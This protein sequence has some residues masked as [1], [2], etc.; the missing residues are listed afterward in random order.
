MFQYFLCIAKAIS[1]QGQIAKAKTIFYVFGLNQISKKT[2][3]SKFCAEVRWHWQHAFKYLQCSTLSKA[4]SDILTKTKKLFFTFFMEITCETCQFYIFL[5]KISPL[6]MTM[7]IKLELYFKLKACYLNFYFIFFALFSLV[8]RVYWNFSYSS[9][10][11][12]IIL[13]LFYLSFLF[14]YLEFINV[15]YFLLKNLLVEH[16]IS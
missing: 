7:H 5:K 12:F 13:L 6:S 15:I 3:L 2:T 14:F 8:F 1:H 9:S 16:S 4:I 11:F 10:S